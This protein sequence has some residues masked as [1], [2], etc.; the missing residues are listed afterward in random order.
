M[1][2][3]GYTMTEGWNLQLQG[4]VRDLT[5]ALAT[6][7]QILRDVT[8]DMK[9]SPELRIA[10]LFLEEQDEKRRVAAAQAA[11]VETLLNAEP[12]AS[13]AIKGAATAAEPN[14]D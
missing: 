3:G 1:T 11:D 5:A 8:K 7:E 2:S 9:N 13:P 10:I 6:A 14:H 4:Q 12:D